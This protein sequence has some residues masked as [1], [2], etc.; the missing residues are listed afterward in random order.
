MTE[1]HTTISDSPTLELPLKSLLED[2]L[3]FLERFVNS[4]EEIELI[5]SKLHD[6]ESLQELLEI[7]TQIW[8][9]FTQKL[10]TRLDL[11]TDSGS[12]SSQQSIAAEYRKLEESLQK[13]ENQIRNHIAIEQQLRLCAETFQARI[14]EMT[15]DFDGEREA[16]G[17]EMAQ[18][19]AQLFDATEER[20][21]MK[22]KIRLYEK[23]IENQEKSIEDLRR[24]MRLGAIS[25][26]RRI[27]GGSQRGNDDVN[28]DV[29]PLMKNT[30]RTNV[31]NPLK[32][33]E[34]FVNLKEYLKVRTKGNN[35]KQQRNFEEFMF[36]EKKAF[37]ELSQIYGNSMKNLF[38]NTK[39][40][41]LNVSSNNVHNNPQNH[42]I[43]MNFPKNLASGGNSNSGSNF[44]PK[45]T[46]VSHT[47][48]NINVTNLTNS[49]IVQQNVPQQQQLPQVPYIVKQTKTRRSRSQGSFK[50]TAQAIG[51]QG[52]AI[53]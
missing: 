13:H 7:I 40:K 28:G 27:S 46:N 34:S 45:N 42:I 32:A 49:L 44:Y 43:N 37:A 5:E 38:K 21:T 8:S 19:K 41:P 3:S 18:L 33:K 30:G 2:I 25:E 17:Q 9:I 6:Y 10:S 31:H 47:N 24:K 23:T 1:P 35:G 51:V 12:P 20:E 53:K 11:L 36:P 16:R 22:K 15:R 52:F 26:E 14:E 50:K 48:L 29:S 39:K 4:Q